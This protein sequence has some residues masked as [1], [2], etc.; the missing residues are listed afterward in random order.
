M[1]L[2]ELAKRAVTGAGHA[3][4]EV[5]AEAAFLKIVFGELAGAQ[6]CSCGRGLSSDVKLIEVRGLHLAHIG[7]PVL[8]ITRCTRRFRSHRW[9]GLARLGNGPGIAI[10][11][12][13]PSVL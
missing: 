8:A 12:F 2:M 13:G 11:P 3:T 4:P 6:L 9:S 5:E 7:T 1:G 10:T